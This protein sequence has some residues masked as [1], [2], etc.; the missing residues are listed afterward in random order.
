MGG[1]VLVGGLEAAFEVISEETIGD[2]LDQIVVEAELEEASSKKARNK[3]ADE[4]EAIADKGGAEAPALF[5]LASKLRKG[6]H[7]TTGLK[8]SKQVT[9][10]LK[11]NGI[12]EEVEEG[13]KK[14]KYTIK[15]KNGKILG[16]YNSG[17]K[18]QKAMDDLMQKGDYDKLE[19]SLVEEAPANSVAGGNIEFGPFV[20]KKRKNAKVQTEMFGG[21]KVF[22]VSPERFFD[23][24][25]GKSRY[26]RYEKYVG[27]DKLGEAIRQYGRNN[28]KN[29]IILKNSGNGAMLYLKYGN[30]K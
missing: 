3:A 11:A 27:N 2:V 5:S 6:T 29:S 19:V 7:S 20:K 14:G 1:K 13:W 8:L 15:D 10:I 16:T 9:S 22:V 21:Q 12:K 30:K 28:P 25:L 4:I 26:A 18:A 23:S 24:R 17:G